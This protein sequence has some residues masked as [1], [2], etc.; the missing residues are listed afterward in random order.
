M[1]DFGNI[2][3]IFAEGKLPD[4]FWNERCDFFVDGVRWDSY[5]VDQF[6][7]E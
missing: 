3:G 4:S 6:F 7:P 5:C 2:L 1:D